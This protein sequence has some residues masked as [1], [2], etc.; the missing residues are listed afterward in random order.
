MESGLSRMIDNLSITS[1]SDYNFFEVKY[2]IENHL[3]YSMSNDFNELVNN[4]CKFLL[5]TRNDADA[6]AK[7]SIY[8][9]YLNNNFHY[10]LNE[11][12]KDADTVR[13]KT[14]FILGGHIYNN[15]I[16]VT[17]K[18]NQQTEILKKYLESISATFE[19]ILYEDLINTPTIVERKIAKIMNIDQLNLSDNI[20]TR[21]SS[22]NYNE[23]LIFD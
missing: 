8:A 18:I 14:P 6:Q 22:I 4:N 5:L 23:K 11:P 17:S 2:G 3:S 19:V 7:S 15:L 20:N 10:K 16:D 21:K 9:H 12:Q 1:Y 13:V